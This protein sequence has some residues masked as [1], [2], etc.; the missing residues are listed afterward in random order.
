VNEDITV[1]ALTVIAAAAEAVT[2]VPLLIVT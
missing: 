2:P 1:G